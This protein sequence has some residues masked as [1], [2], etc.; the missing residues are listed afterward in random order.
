M[1][2]LARNL[3][4]SALL[5]LAIPLLYAE[6]FFLL[7]G[8]GGD[9][10]IVGAIASPLVIQVVVFF[11]GLIAVPKEGKVGVSRAIAYILFLVQT[12]GLPS[13]L[14]ILAYAKFKGLNLELHETLRLIWAL[15][16]SASALVLVLVLAKPWR[17]LKPR[18]AIN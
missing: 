10:S 13:S 9:P 3:V 2:N 16:G 8:F 1:G 14:S 15:V 5:V 18:P 12:V 11:A 6:A 17:L 7:S 4:S